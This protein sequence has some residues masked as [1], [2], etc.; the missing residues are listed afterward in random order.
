MLPFF[1]IL[2]LGG[3]LTLSA[4]THVAI[5]PFTSDASIDT[6]QK[7]SITQKFQSELLAKNVYNI[8]ERSQLELI[9]QEQGLQS[10]GACDAS[11]CQVQLGKLLSVDKLITGSLVRF[12]DTYVL[13]TN[14]LDVQTGS[15]ER[16]WFTK[17]KG[18]ITDVLAEGAPLAAKQVTASELNL[19]FATD[20]L[21]T[22]SSRLRQEEAARAAAMD[23]QKEKRQQKHSQLVKSSLLALSAIVVVTGLGGGLYNNS[24]A[25]SDY[26]DYSAISGTDAQTQT[27]LDDTWDKLRNH[28]N[29]RDKFYGLAGFGVALFL[30]TSIFF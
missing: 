9:L 11:N 13:N 4:A 14:L 23:A 25:N 16:S 30:G 3:A 21:I 20:T 6:A 7:Q 22:G 24:K 8:L 15:I 2:F 12:D 18:S 29:K 19:P 1:R 17:V 26:E 28:E 5:L 10:S 27:A